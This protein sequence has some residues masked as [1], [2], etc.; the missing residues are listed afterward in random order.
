MASARISASLSASAKSPNGRVGRFYRA[1]SSADGSWEKSMVRASECPR[2]DPDWL[3]AKRRSMASQVFDREF[4]CVFSDSG[5]QLFASLDIERAIQPRPDLPLT[6]VNAVRSNMPPGDEFR[7]APVEMPGEAVSY[8]VFC[9]IGQSYDYSTIC[10]GEVRHEA[11]RSGEAQ[12]RWEGRAARSRATVY[13]HIVYMTRIMLG[14]SF[15]ALV[16][17]VSRVMEQLPEIPG[18]GPR[19]RHCGLAPGALAEAFSTSWRR[20]VWSRAA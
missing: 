9:D 1:W 2:I 3:E 15:P 19:P 14:T 16:S 6:V 8:V 11:D 13:V 10:V 12:A 20:K 17:D 4:N 18:A 7:D 5:A